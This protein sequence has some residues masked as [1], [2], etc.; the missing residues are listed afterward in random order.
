[1]EAS[2]G[3]SR[4]TSREDRRLALADG[5]WDFLAMVL[6]GRMWEVRCVYSKHPQPLLGA[7]IC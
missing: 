1:M 7:P 5:F 2:P 6:L 4:S 3:S